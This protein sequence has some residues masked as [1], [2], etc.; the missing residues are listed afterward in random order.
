MRLL[1][2]LVTCCGK[3]PVY[4]HV[5][6]DELNNAHHYCN[7]GACGF[8][9]SPEWGCVSVDEDGYYATDC[10]LSVIFV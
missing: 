10:P 8:E 6:D 7:L 9:P 3:C 4:R 2:A 1:H 5:E